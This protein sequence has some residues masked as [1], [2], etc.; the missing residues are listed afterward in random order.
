MNSKGVAVI[1]GVIIVVLIVVFLS[2]KSGDIPLEI[3]DNTQIEDSVEIGLQIGTEQSTQIKDDASVELDAESIDEPV[4]FDAVIIQ[5]G[6][7]SYFID[8]DGIKH[9]FI[10]VIDD[11]TLEE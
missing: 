8:E 9:Y 6:D 10:E 4:V 7:V 11:P 5:T 3:K 1:I 2:L